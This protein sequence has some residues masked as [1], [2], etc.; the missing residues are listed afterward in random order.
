M[1]MIIDKK[2]M[3]HL[4]NI[5]ILREGIGL[6]AY[7]QRDPLIEYKREG[8]D[9]FQ[10]LLLHIA[11]ESIS[12]INRAVIVPQD[13]QQTPAP[14]VIDVKNLKTNKEPTQTAT[15]RNIKKFGRNDKVSIKKGTQ[16]KTIKWKVAEPLIKNEG[17]AL[18]NQ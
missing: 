15:Q 4:H 17:W 9:M 12:M 1:L 13:Q 11:E 6:R 2:W 3:E 18:V 7:G 5:D 16:Q 8:F 10:D 14:S